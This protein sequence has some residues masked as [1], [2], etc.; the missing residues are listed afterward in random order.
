MI[1]SKCGNE[2]PEGKKFCGHCGNPMTI[3]ETKGLVCSKCGS[4]ITPGKKFC[5]KCGS[6]VSADSQAAAK[7]SPV[8]NEND[9]TVSS[10]FIHWNILPGQIALKID[11]ADIAHYNNVQGFVV[12]DGL[13]AVFFADGVLAG[14]LGAGK[15]P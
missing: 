9:L 11:E 2:V 13:K 14:E 10:G 3:T 7:A 5:G 12:Q 1:C 15:Y 4:P 6:P 8:Q